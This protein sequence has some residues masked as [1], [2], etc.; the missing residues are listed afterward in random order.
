VVI[1]RG[2]LIYDGDLRRL[3]REIRPDKRIVVR[4]GQP[5]PLAELARFGQVVSSGEAQAVLRVAADEVPSAV[6]RMLSALP[7]S[8]LTVEEP[9]LEEVMSELFQSGRRAAS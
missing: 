8:D 2:R 7:V 1:D 5:V 9:P 4:L 6:G 3:S